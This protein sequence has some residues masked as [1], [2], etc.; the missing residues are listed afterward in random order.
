MR[1]LSKIQF[2]DGKEIFVTSP[3]NHISAEIMG[4]RDIVVAHLKSV[5]SKFVPD[6]VV[7]YFAIEDVEV[8]GIESVKVIWKA[9]E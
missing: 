6:Y 4:S 2:G 7:G 5:L 8:N 3:V 1:L 9:G